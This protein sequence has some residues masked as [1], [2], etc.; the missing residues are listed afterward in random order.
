MTYT[1]V[2]G[3]TLTSIAKK[4]NT[5][6]AK[7]KELNPTLIKDVNKICA[8]WTIKV[9]GEADAAPVTKNNKAIVTKPAILTDSRRKVYSTWEWSKHSETDKY[10]VR[11]SYSWGVGI[12]EISETTTKYQYSSFEPPEH[13]THVTIVVTPIAKTKTV[14]Q[15]KEQVEVPLWTANPSDR[16]TFWYTSLPPEVPPTPQV[17]II[18]NT[19]T[20]TLTNLDLEGAESI[21]FQILR[22]GIMDPVYHESD[23]VTIV[24]NR[25][26]YSCKV[27]DGGNYVVRCKARGRN[28]DSD[29]SD[30][31]SD[32]IETRPNSPSEITTCKALSETSVRLEWDSVDGATSYDI[33]YTIDES[34]FNGSSETTTVSSQGNTYTLTGLESGQ[35]YFFRVRAVNNNGSSEWCS[36]TSVIIGAKPAA[37]TTWSSTTTAIVGEP[38]TLYWMHNTEDGSS[39][40]YAELELTVNGETA[41]HT[42]KNSTEEDE[43]DKVSFYEFDTTVYPVGTKVLW[44]VRTKGITDE[45]GDWSIQRTVDIYAQPTL[46]LYASDPSGSSVQTLTMFPIT[47]IGIA[48]PHTQTPI[49]YHLTI[50]SN[51]T[52]ETRDRVGNVKMVQTNEILYSKYFDINTD[53]STSITASDVDLENNIS[54]TINCVASMNSGL[55]AEASIRFGVTWSDDIYAPNAEIGVSTDTYQA[56]IGPYCDDEN[57]E[58]IPDILMSVYRR[59]FDGKFTEIIRDM[60]NARGSYVTDPHPPLDYARYRIVAM[61]TS[62]G[63]MSFYDTP[64]YPV[65]GKAIIIQWDEQWQGFDVAAETGAVS[66]VS[67]TGSMLKLPYNIDVSNSHRPDVEMIEYIG[68]SH[69]VSYYGTQVG[70][71][72]SWRVDIPADDKNTLYAL[73]RLAKWMGDVYVREPS[74]SGYWANITVGFNQTHRG[75][76]I[77]VT[78]DITRVEGGV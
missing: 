69:P 36:A 63:A 7:L 56:I 20:A 75:V 10:E 62:T 70:E 15:G 65:G 33:E 43:K 72:A 44:R 53:L 51:E 78:L 31:Y 46:T 61:T 66:N 25:A 60:P 48:G 64:A 26:S 40:T 8:G 16:Q 9:S 67:W 27:A 57:G 14:T 21:K 58:I 12:E 29:W 32:V 45:Y 28:G 5:T 30:G 38:L 52:Y 50:A 19:L 41:T 55:T 4:F 35:R 24:Q 6:V 49:G 59:E 2:R 47:V 74:G 54:Y 22:E 34:Y 17:S 23:W 76:I 3:D 13:A 1:I 73:R 77:P 11:W 71:T 42:L 39:Q 18:G 37:P 68:R